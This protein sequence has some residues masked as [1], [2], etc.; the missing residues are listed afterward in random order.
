MSE[1]AV[2]IFCNTYNH[3][4][5]IKDALEGFVSQKTDFKFEVLVHDDASTD[6]TAEVIREYEEKYPDII[7]PIYQT[8][9]QYSKG[10]KITKEFQYPRAKGRYVAYCEGDD[11]WIDPLK[12]QRQYDALESHPDVDICAHASRGVDPFSKKV[13]FE[14]APKEKKDFMIIPVED[15]ILEGGNSYVATSALFC[16]RRLI[17]E[18]PEFR[19]IHTYDYTMQIWG[20]LRGGMIYLGN[21]MSEYR[22]HVPGSWTERVWTNKEKRIAHLNRTLDMLSQLDKDT[23]YKYREAIRER[24][25]R[26]RINKLSIEGKHKEILGAEYKEIVN[27]YPFSTKVGVYMR[28]YLPFVVKIRNKLIEIKR[29]QKK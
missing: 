26:T 2:S 3:G 29:G 11:Y 19:R 21:V 27:K 25:L 6:N 15:V 4:S 13:I 20:A 7:K 9:N 16:R 8:E 12:L 14:M 23:D 18:T 10:V 22:T 24:S 1:I 5:F 17:E 28:A